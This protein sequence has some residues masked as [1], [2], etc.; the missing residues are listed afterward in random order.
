MSSPI[1]QTEQTAVVVKATKV[2]TRQPTLPDKYGKFIQFAYYMMDNVLGDEFQMDKDAFLEKIALFGSV[3]EQQTLVQGF[4]NGA[5]ETKGA[6]KTLL[7]DRKKALA[8]ANKPPK[9][10]RAKKVVPITDANGEV[11]PK[12]ARKSTPK[13]GVQAANAQLLDD[14]VQI[15]QTQAAEPITPPTVVAEPVVTAPVVIAPV[16]TEE[17][18]VKKAKAKAAKKPTAAEPVV[19][20]PAINITNE[21]VAETFVAHP[22]AEQPVIAKAAAAAPK[23]KSQPKKAAKQ[24]DQAPGTPV[25][26]DIVIA[27]TDIEVSVINIDGKSYFMD[28]VSNLYCHPVPSAN[29]IGKY[30]PLTRKITYIN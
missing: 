6:I 3:G 28:D 5:K 24:V 21:L 12:R 2:S 30:N 13:K 19:E 27:G 29:S 7:S 8:K 16:V 1:I 18:P 4:L 23:R 26:D 11:A 22:E 14:L 15:A 20:E 25:L 9:Q 17:K 10:S